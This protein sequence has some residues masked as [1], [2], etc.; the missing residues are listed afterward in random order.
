M[1][2][3]LGILIDLLK[4]ELESTGGEMLDVG[5]TAEELTPAAYEDAEIALVSVE[6]AGIRYWEDGT[7]PTATEG[8]FVGDGERFPILSSRCIEGFRAIRAEG[9]DAK[10]VVTYYRRAR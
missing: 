8:Q 6:D 10:L 1:S 4:A 7:D 2:I 3:Q 9:V 5:A